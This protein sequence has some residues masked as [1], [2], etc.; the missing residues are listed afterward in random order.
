M[1]RVGFTGTRNGMTEAQKEAVRRELRGA[2]TFHHGDCVGADA[3]A[4]RIARV[5][6][7]P[8]VIHPPV[9]Q[10]H[11]AFCEDYDG[12]HPQKTHFARNRD[13]VDACDVLIATPWQTREPV[14]SKG[15]TWYTV[16]YARKKQKPIV[17]VWPDGSI[18]GES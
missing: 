6:R 2:D 16:G 5:Q 18:L 13:I 1:K 12:M 9:D 8:V 11:R 10:A 7:I 4:H 15:G 3:E 14:P 17:I